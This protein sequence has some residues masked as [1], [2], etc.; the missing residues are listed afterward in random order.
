MYFSSVEIG[1][2]LLNKT[3][4]KN[5]FKNIN[6]AS[7]NRWHKPLPPNDVIEIEVCFSNNA[8]N[9]EFIFLKGFMLITKKLNFLQ[10]RTTKRK[11]RERAK[12]RS[13]NCVN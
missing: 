9:L 2:L 10:N 3:F 13:K 12:A 7:G 6:S 4:L 5:Y 8:K 11:S 1:V